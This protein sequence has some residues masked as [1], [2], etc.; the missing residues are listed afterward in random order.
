MTHETTASTGIDLQSLVESHDRPFVII[1]HDY[2]IVA[3]NTAYEQIYGVTPCEAVG[4]TCFSVIHGNDKPC[5]RMGESCPHAQVFAT[6]KK[7]TCLHVHHGTDN[8]THQ[9]RVTA[10]PLQ[11]ADGQLFM[12]ELIEDITSPADCGDTDDLMVGQSKPFLACLEQL[13]LAAASDSTVLLRGETGT[14]KELAARFIHD[15]SARQAAPFLVVDCSALTGPLFETEVFGRAEDARSGHAD[16]SAGL[17]EQAGAGTLFL[18]N[19]GELTGSVQAKVLRV[20]E[21]G[22][23]R[24]AGSREMLRLDARIICATNRHLWEAVLAGHFRE[25]LYYRI[26]CLNIQIPKLSERLDDIPLLA[27]NLLECTSRTMQH[28]YH[29]TDAAVQRLMNYHYPGNVRELR[30]ILNTAANCCNN[31]M[32]DADLTQ[33]AVFQ[34]S[35]ARERQHPDPLAA[36]APALQADATTHGNDATA[37]EDH[38]S[39]RA[40]EARYIT[41]LLQRHNGNRRKVA[42]AL[43][44]SVRTLYRKLNRY[45]LS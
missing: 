18:D 23:Y 38:T 42:T 12:G 31:G 33:Q 2:R 11:S 37:A 45:S 22:Q 1:D 9:V 4:N 21:N 28:N 40:I 15:H 8:H 14:G 41:E 13:N 27:K 32:I 39:L 3:S 25:D 29:L 10:Y 24:Q 34:Q 36:A 30:N 16:G 17:F 26:T 43:G 5:D 6:G 7:H 35:R 44:I 20:L 19:I